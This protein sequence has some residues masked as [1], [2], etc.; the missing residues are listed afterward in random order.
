MSVIVKDM[1]MPTG[2]LSC[3]F[4]IPFVD[5][6]YCRRLM[7]RAERAKRLPDCPI[8][9]R[10]PHGDLIDRDALIAQATFVRD[11]KD[12]ITLCVKWRDIADAPVVVSGEVDKDGRD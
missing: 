12:G 9:P 4:C 3:D 8:V 6:P 10:P 2:C 7:R 5:E 11:T 1:E